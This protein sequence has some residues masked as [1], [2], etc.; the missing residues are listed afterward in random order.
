MVD[1]TSFGAPIPGESLTSSPTKRMPWERPPQFTNITDA[2]KYL[3]ERLTIDTNLSDI[4]DMLRKGITVEEVSRVILTAGFSEGKWNNDLLLLL[5]EPLM[6]LLYFLSVQSG[7]DPIFYQEEDYDNE[8]EEDKET[9]LTK[10]KQELSKY[11][12]SGLMEKQ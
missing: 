12:V 8:P 3:Y 6:Y 10:S 9:L 7:V 1:R 4:I 11:G 5:I 2:V